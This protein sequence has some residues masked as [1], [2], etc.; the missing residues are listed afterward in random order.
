MMGGEEE[1]EP[2]QANCFLQRSKRPEVPRHHAWPAIGASVGAGVVR[3]PRTSASQIRALAAELPTVGPE[4]ALAILLAFLNREQ[5][6]FS[7][8]AARGV[9]ADVRAA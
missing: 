5:Q 1:D 8:T 3:H 9:D 2:R 7:R 4:D 6:S